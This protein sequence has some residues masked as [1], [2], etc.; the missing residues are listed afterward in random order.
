MKACMTTR[1]AGS[2][3]ARGAAAGGTSAAA[4]SGGE[5]GAAGA[6]AASTSGKVL[7]LM[8]HGTT[9]MNVYLSRPGPKHRYG[10]VGFVDP[11]E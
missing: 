4:A 2:K 10:G 11:L 1:S 9:E 3:R 7:H 6:S 8:R 5:S